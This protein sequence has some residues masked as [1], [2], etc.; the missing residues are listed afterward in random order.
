M[1]S[2]P[3]EFLVIWGVAALNLFHIENEALW[4]IAF[5]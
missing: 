1:G 2:R 4:L 3:N 5:E